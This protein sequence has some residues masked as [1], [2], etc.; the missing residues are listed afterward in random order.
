MHREFSQ[1]HRSRSG[2]AV[3]GWG[4]FH[5]AAK[6]NRCHA[7]Q[8]AKR[9]TTYSEKDPLQGLAVVVGFLLSVEPEFVVF[10]V[11][12]MQIEENSGGLEHNK[13]VTRA[14]NEDGNTAV[15]G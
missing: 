4:Q 15:G 9:T 1:A 6:N 7:P 10:V 5:R 13:V 8:G 3:L 11:E 2:S 12:L 14:V